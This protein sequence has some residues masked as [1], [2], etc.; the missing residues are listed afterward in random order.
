MP[1]D[2]KP[3]ATSS[4]RRLCMASSTAGEIRRSTRSSSGSSSAHTT[5]RY[6]RC[7]RYAACFRNTSSSNSSRF[8]DA[9]SSHR[10][11]SSA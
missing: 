3:L 5:N 1:A 6:S 4:C 9:P 8:V 2:T 7:T 10:T 11:G